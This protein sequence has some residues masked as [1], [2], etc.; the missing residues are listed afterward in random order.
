MGEPQFPFPTTIAE[1][2]ELLNE[3]TENWSL[4]V[5][6]RHETHYAFDGDQV[7]FVAPSRQEVTIFLAGIFLA[8]FHGQDLDG[9]RDARVRRPAVPDTELDG[10]RA[11]LAYHNDLQPV[12]G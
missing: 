6:R 1:T 11:R 5:M 12:D 4:T 10:I 3:L 7:L 9:L 2:V 8:A